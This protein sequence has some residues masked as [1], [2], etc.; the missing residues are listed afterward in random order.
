VA[1]RPLLRH[2]YDDDGECRLAD[3]AQLEQIAAGYGSRPSF[4]TDL[5][6]D[7]PDGTSSRAEEDDCL[8]LS[9]MHSAKGQEWRIVRVLNVT[10]GCI[11][12]G[13]AEDVVEEERRLL[14]VAIT[15][16]KRELDL[17]LPKRLYRY[18]QKFDGRYVDG[19]VSL[20]IPDGIR[21]SFD[22]RGRRDRDEPA[23][24]CSSR[25]RH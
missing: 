14:H 10:D 15:R 20:F 25:L 13:Q 9:T 5:A 16:A 17:I 7:P 4:L 22:C 18:R 2:N 6:L 21:D 23:G 24:R 8:I 12:S 11:P 3:I 1:S 19:A